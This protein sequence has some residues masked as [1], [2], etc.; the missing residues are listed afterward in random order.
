MFVGIYGT[1]VLYSMGST[2]SEFIETMKEKANGRQLLIKNIHFLEEDIEVDAMVDPPG[3]IKE[4]I[5]KRR[6]AA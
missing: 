1:K 4:I 6:K 5:S 2:W 3:W